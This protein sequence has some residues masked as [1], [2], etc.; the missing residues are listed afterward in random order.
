MSLEKPPGA[1]GNVNSIG[2]TLPSGRPFLRG[3][4][5]LG[6][7]VCTMLGMKRLLSQTEG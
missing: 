4:G 2:E 6:L 1:G 7:L 3:V 5:H